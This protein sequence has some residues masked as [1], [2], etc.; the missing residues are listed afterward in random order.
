MSDDNTFILKKREAFHLERV[1]LSENRDAIAE[2]LD[3]PLTAI[4]SEPP[5]ASSSNDAGA[6]TCMIVTLEV[7]DFSGF[8]RP[9]LRT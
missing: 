5:S 1:I 2:A 9:W 3:A 8:E 6:R 7:S 4:A